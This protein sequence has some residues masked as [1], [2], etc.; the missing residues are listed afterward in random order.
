MSKDS[1]IAWSSIIVNGLFIIFTS[2]I[3]CES[4]AS[5]AIFKNSLIGWDVEQ[6]L[7][8]DVFMLKNLPW[9]GMDAASNNQYMWL[10]ITAVW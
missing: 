6:M 8:N 9:A 5:T 4:H 10:W 7:Y 3:D 2:F 1:V